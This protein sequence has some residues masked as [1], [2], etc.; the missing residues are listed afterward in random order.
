MGQ[1][2]MG[3]LPMLLVFVAFYFFLIRPQQK[4]QKERTQMLSNLKKGD[5]VV[6]IGGLHGTIVDLSEEKVTLKVNE[7]TRLVFERSAI[8]SVA[9]ADDAA[10]TK[11]AE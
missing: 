5:K 4:R 2:L 8:N 10:A 11:S 7:N 9:T 3:I 6:T 1:Q